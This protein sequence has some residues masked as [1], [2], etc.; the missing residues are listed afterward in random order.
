MM[1]LYGKVGQNIEHRV[2]KLQQAVE[3][4]EAWALQQSQKQRC[5]FS[6]KQNR[7]SDQSLIM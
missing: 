7:S 3:E 6:L 2:K 1:R 5:S 4:V